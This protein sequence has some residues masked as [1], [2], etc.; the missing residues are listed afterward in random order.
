MGGVDAL[1]LDGKHA[2]NPQAG[3]ACIRMHYEGTYGWVGVAWQNPPNN[4]GDQDGGFNI[5]GATELEFWARGEY[6][7]EKIS[8]GVGLLEADKAYPDSGKKTV[9]GIV[10]TRD[11]QRYS[12]PLKGIDL[13]SIK[14]GFFVTLTGRKTPVTVYLDSIRFIK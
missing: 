5:T 7:G 8:A 14:T 11:W 10:L 4:W 12:I 13:S 3:E 2:E 9:D 6:G 1:T